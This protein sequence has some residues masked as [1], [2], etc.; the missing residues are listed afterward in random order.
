MQLLCRLPERLRDGHLMTHNLK[1]HYGKVVG[2]YRN[3][4]MGKKTGCKVYSVVHSGKVIAHVE[5]I[6]LE[7]VEFK[8]RPA[9]RDRVRMEKRKN[10]HAFVTG[11]IVGSAM[12][13]DAKG[14]LPVPIVYNPYHDDY[15]HTRG[16]FT[17]SL[18]VFSAE[19][20][21]VNQQ[22]VSA[23]YLGRTCP[24]YVHGSG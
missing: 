10:V 1:R 18:Y 16:S 23:A 21:V 11:K 3:L 13:I 7:G 14:D 22:G 24:S 6:L 8:V 5:Q 15:F 20:A 2:V 9:G 12:G 17:P 4:H 19:V